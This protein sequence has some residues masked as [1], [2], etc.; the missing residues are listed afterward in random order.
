[1]DADSLRFEYINN[2]AKKSFWHISLNGLILI[3]LTFI[4]LMLISE[5]LIMNAI[6]QDTLKNSICSKYKNKV[7][8]EYN[9]DIKN[10]NNTNLYSIKYDLNIKGIP[11]IDCKCPK[12]GILNVFK[13]I[14]V[15]DTTTNINRKVDKN[16]YCDTAYYFDANSSDSNKYYEGDSEV[17]RYMI[18]GDTSWIKNGGL[19]G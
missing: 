17:K 6:K 15:F 8:K 13:D 14:K 3:L 5:L 19:F 12:G 18:D 7:A 9:V 11:E 16:C 10:S 2:L 1:M 4:L